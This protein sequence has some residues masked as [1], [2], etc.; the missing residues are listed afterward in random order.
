MTDAQKVR[1]A[2][3]SGALS[4]IEK[5]MI[6][7]YYWVIGGITNDQAISFFA[8]CGYTFTPP[9]TTG[10]TILSGTETY[11]VVSLVTEFHDTAYPSAIIGPFAAQEMFEAIKS[12]GIVLDSELTQLKG[13]GW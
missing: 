11:T 10:A 6:V 5:L 7:F 4:L 3:D 8:E 2:F 1:Y 12:K 13:L 9:T